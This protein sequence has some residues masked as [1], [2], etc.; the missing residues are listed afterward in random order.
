MKDSVGQLCNKTLL[1]K[2]LNI[3][4]EVR[5]IQSS[6]TDGMIVKKFKRADTNL[7]EEDNDDVLEAL[8]KRAMKTLTLVMRNSD[9]EAMAIYECTKRDG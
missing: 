9:L 4:S 8:D 3:N 7:I 2:V 5:I 1:H 6:Q